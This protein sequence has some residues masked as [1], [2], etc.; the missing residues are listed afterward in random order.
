MDPGIS[1][2]GGLLVPNLVSFCVFVRVVRQRRYPSVIIRCSPSYQRSGG[3]PSL[4]RTDGVKYPVDLPGSD[5]FLYVGVVA[6]PNFPDL[7]SS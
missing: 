1:C 7:R 2:E 4:L 6:C 3:A 5:R